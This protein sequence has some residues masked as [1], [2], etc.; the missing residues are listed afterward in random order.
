MPKYKDVDLKL[1]RECC[2]NHSYLNPKGILISKC[3]KCPL[4]R[5]RTTPEGKK[6]GMLC[7]FKLHDLL[8]EIQDEY[9]A[10]EEEDINKPLEWDNYIKSLETVE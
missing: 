10:L 7:W 2:K 5:F 1:A 3:E 8:K 6:Q 4:E 9:N